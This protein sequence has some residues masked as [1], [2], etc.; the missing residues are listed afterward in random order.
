[1]AAKGCVRPRTLLALRR[2]IH[3][4]C[5]QLPPVAPGSLRLS[6]EVGTWHKERNGRGLRNDRQTS[7]RWSGSWAHEAGAQHTPSSKAP[8]RVGLNCFASSP[9]HLDLAAG[10]R[11]HFNDVCDQAG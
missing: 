2:N 9:D 11:N 7:R 3:D 8:F 5:L 10:R 4:T 6:P 1:V